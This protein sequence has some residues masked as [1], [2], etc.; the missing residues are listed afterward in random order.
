MNSASPRHRQ[1]QD[2]GGRLTDQHGGVVL[3]DRG[4][5]G[6]EDVD[7]EGLQGRHAGP[8]TDEEGVHDEGEGLEEG[9]LLEHRRRRQG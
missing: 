9:A 4:A 2:R 7:G 8:V 3:V 5:Y 1:D 6:G